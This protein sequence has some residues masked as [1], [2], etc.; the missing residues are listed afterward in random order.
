M[1]QRS[2]R[3]AALAFVVVSGLVIVGAIVLWQ[4]RNATVREPPSGPSVALATSDDEAE[5]STRD[6]APLPDRRAF[7]NI[8]AQVERGM[9]AAEVR[10]LVGRPDEIDL[11]RANSGEWE[12][13]GRTWRYGVNGR[14]TCP[15]LGWVM[16]D[17]EGTV[18]S[19]AGGTSS[20]TVAGGPT[21]PPPPELMDER[22]LRRLL[23]LLSDVPPC[24]G[25][26]YDPAS[27]IRAVNTL[28]PLG[29]ERALAVIRE[30]LRVGGGESMFLVLRVLFEVPDE[31]G[32]MP[33]MS[34][35]APY[36]P[37]PKDPTLVPRFPLVIQDDIPLMLVR[38]YLV[39]G[40]G[41]G[42]EPHVRYF[43]EHGTLRSKPLRPGGDPLAA[44]DR[45]V[46]SPQWLYEAKYA[47][48]YNPRGVQ[49]VQFSALDVA[50]GRH[51]I[52]DQLLHLVADVYPLPQDR[53]GGILPFRGAEA[54]WRKIKSE[55]AKLKLRWDPQTNRYV[56]GR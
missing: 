55:V 22:E 38:G 21:S 20:L 53:F 47:P 11:R 27:L 7:A 54:R 5:P 26:G 8:M 2:I 43:Q 1:P 37:E 9:T 12:S 56:S 51:M 50:N 15:T 44:L 4:S 29:K 33:R 45:F 13:F 49:V 28:R 48:G 35:G 24:R 42:P 40:A 34:I 18:Q 6:E 3:R 31:P 52:M 41:S 25:L 32:H 39:A 19:V 23:R 16:F 36:P 14:G 10:N 17:R 46:A 30:Y